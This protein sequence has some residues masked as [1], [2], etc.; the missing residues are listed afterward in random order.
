MG[1]KVHKVN[2]PLRGALFTGLEARSAVIGTTFQ[3]EKW[4]SIIFNSPFSI[5]HLIRCLQDPENFINLKNFINV[6]LSVR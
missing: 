6:N 2:R 5:F 4:K 1:L 3:N